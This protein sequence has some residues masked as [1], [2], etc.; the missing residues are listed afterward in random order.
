M[1]EFTDLS[2]SQTSQGFGNCMKEENQLDFSQTR[3]K[4]L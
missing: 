1:I 2:D 4:D 3:L